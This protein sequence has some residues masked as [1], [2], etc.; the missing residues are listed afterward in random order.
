MPEDEAMA[1]DAEKGNVFQ[2]LGVIAQPAAN[3]V[4]LTLINAQTQY[5]LHINQTKGAYI[6]IG[7]EVIHIPYYQVLQKRDIGKLK[8]E[9]AAIKISNDILWKLVKADRVTVQCGMVI[10]E[11][12]QDNIDALKYLAAQIEK[13]TKTKRQ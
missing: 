3:K 1:A 12:D 10:Y 8:M 7:T 11:L 5:Q 9:T 13:D 4:G 6:T 2:A